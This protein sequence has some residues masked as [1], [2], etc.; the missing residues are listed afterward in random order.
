MI[1]T[2]L[3]CPNVIVNKGF[4]VKVL[5]SS[6]PRLLRETLNKWTPKS[7]IEEYYSANIA[8]IVNFRRVYYRGLKIGDPRTKHLFC[9]HRTFDAGYGFSLSAFRYLGK[10]R[11]SPLIR[12]GYEE[13]KESC[14]A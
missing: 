9:I 11:A 4:H 5:V 7:G 2:F 3:D 1:R 10:I 13:T 12:I 8:L 14:L 6:N